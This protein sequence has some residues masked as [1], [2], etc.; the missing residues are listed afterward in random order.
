MVRGAKAGE[1]VNKFYNQFIT[2]EL[3]RTVTS[4]EMA[5]NFTGLHRL[6]NQKKAIGFHSE[7]GRAEKITEDEVFPLW[8]P[9]LH[10][11]VVQA[12]RL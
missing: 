5:C 9:E 8:K 4:P 11:V 1:R 3:A 10:L 7:N 2:I 6:P 12:R